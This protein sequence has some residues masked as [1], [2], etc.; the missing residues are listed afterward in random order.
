MR[1]ILF[2][3]S[4]REFKP[5]PPSFEL[6]DIKGMVYRRLI[7]TSLKPNDTFE[8]EGTLYKVIKTG[9]RRGCPEYEASYDFIAEPVTKPS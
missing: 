2:G 3:Q 9:Y 7:G 5:E 6:E 8:H 4:P 1:V